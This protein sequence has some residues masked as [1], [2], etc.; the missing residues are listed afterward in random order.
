MQNWKM[1]GKFCVKGHIT[2]KHTS[3]NYFRLTFVDK[4]VALY[5]MR[6][7][8][9]DNN[10]RT[11]NNERICKRLFNCEFRY[12]FDYIRYPICKPIYFNL[13]SLFRFSFFFAHTA[14]DGVVSSRIKQHLGIWI[15]TFQ[16]ARFRAQFPCYRHRIM[17]MWISL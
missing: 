7:I 16:S 4:P 2:Q 17:D 9:N 3:D 6:K 10:N 12:R 11:A 14:G 5:D 15:E 1:H 8:N 13:L